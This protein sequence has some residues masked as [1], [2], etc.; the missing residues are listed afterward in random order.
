MC[1]ASSTNGDYKTDYASAFA[2]VALTVSS[3]TTA[4]TLTPGSATRDSET[5]ATVKFTSDEAGEYYYAVVESGAEEPSIDTT[6][7][8]TSCISGENTISPYHAHRIGRKG[9]YIVVKDA[10]RECEPTAENHHTRLYRTQ[11]WDFRVPGCAGLWQQNGRLYGSP[12][13]ADGNAHK[14]GKPKCNG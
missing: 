2:E 12:R 11:L 14:Y 8:G 10:A 6:V 13:R 9:S 5:A 3:D 1:S 4:P 7:A